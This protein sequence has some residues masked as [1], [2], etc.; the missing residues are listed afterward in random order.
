MAGLDVVVDVG[1]VTVCGH[2]L[3]AVWCC[4]EGEIGRE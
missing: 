2:I 4:Y 1:V 3:C